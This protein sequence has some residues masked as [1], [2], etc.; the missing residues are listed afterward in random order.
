MKRVSKFFVIGGVLLCV[1]VA[2]GWSFR[3]TECRHVVSPD[4]R[5]YA[6]AFCRAWR[7]YVPMMPGSSGDKPGYVT[8]FTRDG[9]SCGTAPLPLAWM[10]DEIE[11]S[12][13]HAELRL[14]ADW[15][16]VSHTVH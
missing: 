2:L 4:G 5:F 12:S 10:V 16:L 1:M 14:V 9:R 11:W 8:V 6:V 7:A 15:D 3:L 13:N